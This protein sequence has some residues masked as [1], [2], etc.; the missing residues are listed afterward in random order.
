MTCK[1]P[2][3]TGPYA[4][5]FKGAYDQSKTELAKRILED[6]QI[7]D[8]ELNEILDAQNQCLAPYGLVA[9]KGQLAR[10]RESALSDEEMNQKNS[11]CAEKTDLWNVESMYDAMQDNPDNLDAEALHKASY[12]CLK[13]HDLLP[14]PL[15]EQEY[16]DME[17]SSSQGL[18]E[19]QIA[20]RI[21]KWNEFYNVYMEYND[22]GIRNPNYD[23]AK[24]TQFWQCQTDPMNQ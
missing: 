19:E 20:E 7:T 6:C 10:L 24:A 13:T 23:A 11:E 1:A 9:T 18:S 3:F 22:D 2:D 12:E 14:K 4:S 5:E 21:R 15:T 8:A 16:L 17:V